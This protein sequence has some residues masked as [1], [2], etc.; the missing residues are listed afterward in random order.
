M[1]N[2]KEPLRRRAAIAALLDYVDAYL[3]LLSRAFSLGLCEAARARVKIH[4]EAV[5]ED[6]SIAMLLTRPLE[7]HGKG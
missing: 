6:G 7:G 4:E 2:R 5:R 1:R 3:A